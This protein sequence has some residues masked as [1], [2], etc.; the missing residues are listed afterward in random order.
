MNP[1]SVHHKGFD[2][3]VEAVVRRTFYEDFRI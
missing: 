2:F 1:T 3:F